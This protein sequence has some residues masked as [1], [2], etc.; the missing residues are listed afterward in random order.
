MP[1]YLQRSLWVLS[2]LAM[3]LILWW[4]PGQTDLATDPGLALPADPPDLYVEDVQQTYYNRE[5]IPTGTLRA[6]S[7]AFYEDRGSSDIINP[8]LQ[9]LED[10]VVVWTVQ[11]LR[12][13]LL[14]NGDV[15]FI[16]QV[17]VREE[18][19]AQPWLL[20]TDWLRLEQEGRFAT[21]PSPVKLTQGNQLATGIGLDAWLTGEKPELILKSEVA[22]HYEMDA[23]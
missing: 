16:D 15:E 23:R 7:L 3:A 12:A 4:R 14:N 6:D 20:E 22:I 17:E 13:L 9:Q 1:R 10:E 8:Q 5:G 11:S 2:L 19:V 18:S 21:T